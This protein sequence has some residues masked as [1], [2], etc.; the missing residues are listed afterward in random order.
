LLFRLFGE[1]WDI[2]EEI[3]SCW[4]FCALLK[5]SFTGNPFFQCQIYRIV[6]KNPKVLGSIHTLKNYTINSV[7][8]KKVA[9][10]GALLYFVFQYQI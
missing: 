4:G 5:L 9:S 8:H 2:E 7:Y 1:F 6:G 10:L 3:R